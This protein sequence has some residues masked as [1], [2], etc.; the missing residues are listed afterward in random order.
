MVVSVYKVLETIKNVINSSLKGIESGS[1]RDNF[2]HIL[3]MI[4][5]YIMDGVPSFQEDNVLASLISP[6]DFTDKITEN[7]IGKTKDYKCTTLNN[8]MREIQSGYDTFKYKNDNI[9]GN[10][11]LLFNFEDILDLI[12]DK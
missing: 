8:F 12:Y 4:D 1:I 9:I 11:Q 6:S 2:I 5:Q 3:L 7:W 10:Y